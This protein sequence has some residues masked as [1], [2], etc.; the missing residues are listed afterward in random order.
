MLG[1]V[2]FGCFYL[3]MEIDINYERLATQGV[4]GETC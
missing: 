3:E 4:S 2:R 1:T